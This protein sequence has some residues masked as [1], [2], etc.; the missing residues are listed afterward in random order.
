MHAIWVFWV[1]E[2][3]S[4][5]LFLLGMLAVGL[6]SLVRFVR[7][8]RRFRSRELVLPVTVV[9][10]E[11]DPD[12]LAQSALECAAWCNAVSKSGTI[13]E[14][15]TERADGGAILS[16]LRL[17][18][19]RFLYL[20]ERCYADVES[21]KRASLLTFLLSLATVAHGATSTY[22]G[23]CEDSNLTQVVC[24]YQTLDQ[25][26][27]TLALG[28]SLCAVLYLVSSFFE[29]KLS[30]RRTCWKYFCSRLRAELSRE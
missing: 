23:I 17:A 18:E 20:W 2:P 25:L 8:A 16:V 7:L 22:F 12:A 21:T 15:G 29:R 26:L 1:L 13:S 6:I 3:F 27:V 4:T 5:K 9:R 24:L 30:D 19:S 28:L 14:L 10:G 11:A